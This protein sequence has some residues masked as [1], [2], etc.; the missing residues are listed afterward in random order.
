M[1]INSE[2]E[3]GEKEIANLK[4][5]LKKKIKEREKEIKREKRFHNIN[6]LS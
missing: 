6:H 5:K 4:K 2:E 3:E 1:C